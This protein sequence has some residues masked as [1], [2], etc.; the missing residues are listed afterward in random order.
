MQEKRFA[1]Y[2]AEKLTISRGG[3]NDLT[4]H[5]GSD[6]H[7]KALLANCEGNMGTFFAILKSTLLM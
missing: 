1:Q 3:K 5:E 2:A 7:K 4:C 6:V